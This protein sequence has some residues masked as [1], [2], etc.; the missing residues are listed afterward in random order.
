M[1][2]AGFSAWHL[3]G[4][5]F[6]RDQAAGQVLAPPKNQATPIMFLFNFVSFFARE[7]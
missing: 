7:K 2:Q 1:C 4:N 3:Q 6:W 5:S